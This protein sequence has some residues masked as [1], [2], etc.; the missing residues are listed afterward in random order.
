MTDVV[1]SVLSAVTSRPERRRD[2]LV[3]LVVVE[4][5]PLEALLDV[6]EVLTVLEDALVLCCLFL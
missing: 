6:A 1:D 3:N 5:G 4:V 2:T